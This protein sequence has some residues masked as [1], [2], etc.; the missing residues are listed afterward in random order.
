MA[1]SGKRSSA[2]AND[3]GRRGGREARR[4]LRSAPLEQGLRPVRA[5]LEGGRS[6]PLTPADIT[7][8][9]EAALDVLERLGI[10]QALPSCVEACTARGAY[11][12][13]HGRLSFPR[14]LVEDV[15]AGAA[16]RFP[17]YGQD[18][19]HDLEPWGS[20][21][22]Y[23]TAGGAARTEGPQNPHDPDTRVQ[24]PYAPPP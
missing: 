11:V 5:G 3:T 22:H 23:G 20:K 6:Q 24:G 12:N 7:T 21:V 17:L 13:E 19:C 18:P 9:H 2:M 10:A 16:R 15:V 8:I 4:Q 1:Q 14:A